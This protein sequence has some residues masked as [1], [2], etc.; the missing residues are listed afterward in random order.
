MTKNDHATDLTRKRELTR[1]TREGRA[2]AYRKRAIEVR[3]MAQTLR[4]PDAQ[5]VLQDVAG[6]YERMSGALLRRYENDPAPNG[7]SK[8]TSH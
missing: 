6:N 1:S 8:F 3:A 7:R 5:K 2:E 4:D